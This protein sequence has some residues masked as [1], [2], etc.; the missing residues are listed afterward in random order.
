MFVG[1]DFRE[2]ASPKFELAELFCLV[3]VLDDLLLA[4]AVRDELCRVCECFWCCVCVLETSGVCDYSREQEGCDVFV[5]QF[6]FE[7][8][9]H[10]F[11]E[12]EKEFGCRG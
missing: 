7:C 8:F 6:D 1:L 3:Y 11:E 9:F 10:F 5:D 4:C 2:N 12:W